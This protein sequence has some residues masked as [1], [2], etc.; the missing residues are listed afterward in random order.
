METQKSYPQL[1]CRRSPSFQRLPGYPRMAPY[2]FGKIWS[3]KGIQLKKA[4]DYLQLDQLSTILADCKSLYD[5]LATVETSGLQLTE[6]LSAIEAAGCKVR[7]GQTSCQVRWVNSDRQLADGFTKTDV[8]D[9]Y[10]S[11]NDKDSGR[12]FLI[13]N[14]SPRKRSGTNSHSQ[15]STSGLSRRNGKRLTPSQPRKSICLFLWKKFRHTTIHRLKIF[16]SVILSMLTP[17]TLTRLDFATNNN[18]WITLWHYSV[19]PYSLV[20][21]IARILVTERTTR[22]THVQF[23]LEP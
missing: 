21:Q 4:D 10:G 5:A 6:R 17:P 19:Q 2:L 1:P 13:R 9:H 11:S 16:K 3:T 14:L 8:C 18:S 7:L 23:A 20:Q 12:S 15:S 22:P